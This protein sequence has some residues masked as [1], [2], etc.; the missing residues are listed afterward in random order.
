MNHVDPDLLFPAWRQQC[1][2]DAM[3]LVDRVLFTGSV[4]TQPGLRPAWQDRLN[5]QLQMPNMGTAAPSADTDLATL[6]GLALVSDDEVNDNI[7]VRRLVQ[8]LDAAAE[9]VLRDLVA[10]CNV[11]RWQAEQAGFPQ[12][13]LLE[14]AALAQSLCEALRDCIAHPPRRQAL[15]TD[16]GPALT[17]EGQALYQRQLDW[18]DSQGIAAQPLAIRRSTPLPAA[19]PLV[20]AALTA[21]LAAEQVPGLLERVA[22]Q[23]ELSEGMTHL[24]QGLAP[25]IQRSLNAYPQL[26]DPQHGAA[27]QLIERLASLSQLDPAG[28]GAADKPALDLR[29]APLLKALQDQAGPL[30]PQHYSRALAHAER[31]ALASLPDPVGSQQRDAQALNLQAKQLELEPLIQFQMADRLAKQDLL[32]GVSQFLLGPWVQVLTLASARDGVD[33]ASTQRWAKLIDTLVEGAQRYRRQPL[34]PAQLDCQLLDAQDGLRELG[35]PTA[36]IQQH[37]GDLRAELSHWPRMA[38]ASADDSASLAVAVTDEERAHLLPMGSPDLDDSDW[39]HHAD[40]ATVPVDL[41]QDDPN[42]PAYQ[43]RQAWLNGLVPGQLCRI[44]LQGRWT[45]VRLDW[46]S[47]RDQYYAFSRRRGPAFST[48]RRVLERMRAEGLVTSVDPGQ[49]LREAV[50][51]LPAHL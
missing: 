24:L 10:R 41:H 3:D 48:P 44:F 40:L 7:A 36:R 22:L 47:E 16:I 32:P 27:W 42:G 5:R 29:L 49:W 12:P 30:T 8:A 43:D 13:L 19:K 45:S 51:T 18:L 11:W 31:L 46:I 37:L 14:P 23:A 15:L 20:T 33:V 50:D 21:A 35:M 17:R 9:W 28:S 26:L 2:D 39:Q 6:S 38:L 25:L 34:S 4:A 1:L